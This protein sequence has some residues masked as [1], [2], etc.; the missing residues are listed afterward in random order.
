MKNLSFQGEATEGNPVGSQEQEI[1]GAYL[2]GLIDGD[3]SV[4]IQKKKGK[5]KNGFRIKVSVLI[6]QKGQRKWF[7]E[8]IQDLLGFGRVRMRNDGIAQFEV[9]K[10]SDALT[11][12]K[13]IHPYS[14]LKRKKIKVALDVL[15][16]KLGWED[17]QKMKEDL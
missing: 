6:F 2:A 12:L 5:Y 17:I 7:L 16:G 3:G 14:V 4:V 8:K 11:L 15:N 10:K 9:E 13:M 1:L